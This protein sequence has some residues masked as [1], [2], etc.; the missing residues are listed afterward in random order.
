MSSR[1]TPASSAPAVMK[2]GR[3]ALLRTPRSIAAPIAAAG[4]PA[5]ITTIQ[6]TPGPNRP[7]SGPMSVGHGFGGVR[8]PAPAHRPVDPQRGVDQ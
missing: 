8:E 1:R 6:A 4:I 7:I 5:I 3:S 2:R